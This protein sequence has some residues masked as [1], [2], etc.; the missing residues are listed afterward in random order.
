MPNMIA[1][2]TPAVLDALE[3]QAPNTYVRVWCKLTTPTLPDEDRQVL[4][5]ELYCTHYMHTAF[6]CTIEVPIK[7]LYRLAEFDAIREISRA[8]VF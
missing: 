5:E 3:G 4:A 8:V 6:L 1:K 2:A 7:H